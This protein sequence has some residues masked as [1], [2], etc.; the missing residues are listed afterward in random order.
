MWGRRAARIYSRDA[1]SRRETDDPRQRKKIFF[2]RLH[3]G[4][5]HRSDAA[6]R[7]ARSGRRGGK[8][9]LTTRTFSRTNRVSDSKKFR[10]GRI[11]ERRR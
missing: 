7:V 4:V 6:G 5:L 8:R 10:D 11:A 9:F 1:L 3:S 2:G